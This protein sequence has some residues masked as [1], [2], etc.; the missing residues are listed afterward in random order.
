MNIGMNFQNLAS[1]IG[2]PTKA[3]TTTSINLS[4]RDTDLEKN[5]FVLKSFISLLSSAKSTGLADPITPSPEPNLAKFLTPRP[6]YAT[7]NEDGS[8]S[9]PLCSIP[10]LLLHRKS[11]KGTPGLEGSLSPLDSAA[12]RL[13][14]P[15]FLDENEIESAPVSIV[16]HISQS[17]LNL[18][19]SRLRSSKSALIK[20]A[21]K[22][23]SSLS[24]E[25]SLLINL[26]NI[27][28]ISLN[29]VVTSFRVV[30][31][32]VNR[33]GYNSPEVLLPLVFEAVMDISLL[34][35]LATVS[36][37]TPGTVVGTFDRHS[38]RLQR[39]EVEYNTFALLQAMMKQARRCV[40]KT[41]V[42]GVLISR[43][44]AKEPFLQDSL[45]GGIAS[46]ASRNSTLAAALAQQWKAN[47]LNMHVNNRGMDISKDNGD[48]SQQNENNEEPYRLFSWLEGD[49]MML[50]ED[51]LNQQKQKVS[52]TTRNE[53]FS[54]FADENFVMHKRRKVSFRNLTYAP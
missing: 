25:S 6:D 5:V 10:S 42:K 13:A 1:L 47:N 19:E 29:T 12:F 34:G 28:S 32:N 44:L 26:L 48:N 4:Q 49:K 35:E 14:V 52:E 16:E 39:V 22:R 51:S 53:S 9:K 23:H 11:L 45:S 50:T 31:S 46:K 2:E 18:I 17:F 21:Y 33:N 20:Q 15:M 30:P 41:I 24:R 27:S 40:K 37:Q 54:N 7:S 38:G 8:K 36:F 43:I 3:N